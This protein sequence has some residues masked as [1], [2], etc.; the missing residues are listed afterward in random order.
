MLHIFWFFPLERKTTNVNGVVHVKDIFEILSSYSPRPVLDD[1]FSN[2]RD[3]RPALRV[4]SWNLHLMSSEKADN[5]GIREVFCRTILE[6][7]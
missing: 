3:G 4:A 6:N 2:M 7:R 5:P 1:N